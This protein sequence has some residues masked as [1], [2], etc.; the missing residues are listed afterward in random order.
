VVYDLY[1]KSL[2]IL[3]EGV[4]EAGNYSINWAGIDRHG[5]PLPNGVYILKLKAGTNY[6][7]TKVVIVK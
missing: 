3:Q 5:K 6:A 2:N 1:G 7:Q 4:S